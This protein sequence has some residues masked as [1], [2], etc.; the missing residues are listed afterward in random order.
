MLTKPHKTSRHFLLASAV[1][2]ALL[3]PS[4]SLGNTTQW[5]PVTNVCAA[6]PLIPA[7]YTTQYSPIDGKGNNRRSLTWGMA[8]QTLLRVLPQIPNREPG[9]A[10]A[11]NLP[12]PRKVSNVVV[13]QTNN[14]TVNSKGLS[15]ILW[16]WGQFLDHDL[17]LV[18]TNV[19]VE[20]ANIPVPVGDTTFDPNGTGIVNLLFFRSNYVLDANGKRQHPNN[21]TSFIDAS[22]V[23]GSD[24]A[25]ANYLRT[26]SGGKMKLDAQ[27]LL[28]KN[29][30]GLYQA[31]DERVN[32]NIGLTAMHTLWVREHNRLADAIACKH[33]DWSDERIYQEARRIVAAEIQAI[34]YNEF[35]PALLGKNRLPG[36]W[37]Y[38]AANPKQFPGYQPNIRPDVSNAFA[39]ATFRLGHTLLS[40]TLLRL[41]ENGTVIPQ[42][43]V[44]LRD[45]FFQ[46]GKVSEAGISPI[47]RGFASQTAQAVDPMIIDDV[48]NFLFPQ[49]GLDLAS[50]NIQRGRDHGLPGYNDARA[51]LGLPR[52]TSF[53]HPIWR[54]GFGQKLEQVYRHPDQVD[55]WV[56]GLAEKE[57]GEALV[58]ETMVSILLD[59]F[60]RLR[61]GDRFWYENQFFG[62]QLTELHDLRLSDVIKR[63]TD[64]V[65]IQPDVFKA[66]IRGA[67]NGQP[68][69][70]TIRNPTV[71]VNTL[72]VNDSEQIR[73][74]IEAIAKGVMG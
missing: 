25:G 48:R 54:A 40:P 26:L 60:S 19:P 4:I 38:S 53:N 5:S 67:A 20:E 29:P 31:G 63:N 1:A 55:L 52:I 72:P 10:A 18:A 11:A 62:K 56:G 57:S 69:N 47:F 3:L 13:S 12:N 34:T 42:G 41:N 8:G 44:R 71:P 58:G 74:I 59:Q 21:I 73:R 28:P 7:W 46:P 61:Q 45:A 24:A 9:N 51:S 64:I 68:G 30:E 17:D 49:G 14:Q 22:N 65:N 27:G 50:V 39:A 2:S 23:Y 37:K 15:D 6:N 43:N 32:E 16:M 33:A 35:L 66:Q 70:T 36:Y